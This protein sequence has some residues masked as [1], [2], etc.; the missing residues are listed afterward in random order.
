MSAAIDEVVS[1]TRE[2][3]GP[4][5]M[6][7]GA[8]GMI[9]T[10][11]RA[12]ATRGRSLLPLALLG[13]A[14]LPL[15]AFHA[16]HPERVRYMVIL[17]VA[18]AAIGGLALAALPG[19]L[20]PIAAAVWLGLAL[21]LR[22]PFPSTGPMLAEAQWELPFAQARR[23]VTAYLTSSYDGTPI[24][25]SMGSLAHYMQEVAR[26]GFPLR[27]FLHEGNGDLW[28]DALSAPRHHVRWIL[29]EE[30]ALGGDLLARRARQDASFLDG[31]TRVSAGG[32]LA[33]YR[34]N[35]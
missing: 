29:I 1:T 21:W 28:M 32:G 27:D 19:R 14:V 33:L 9:A 35:P 2:L 30:Q 15:G 4:A 20:R 34:R 22:P 26:S 23:V 7:V 31:F 25:A 8:A 18:L 3:G 6:L 10:V 12:H 16:G 13:A 11:A 5:V 24:L 17:V